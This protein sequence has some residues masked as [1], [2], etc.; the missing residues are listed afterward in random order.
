MHIPQILST[1]ALFSMRLSRSSV[2]L[3]LDSLMCRHTG[4][5]AMGSTLTEAETT[6]L[7]R[8]FNPGKNHGAIE[9][10]EFVEKLR[11]SVIEPTDM[12][13]HFNLPVGSQAVSGNKF[14][15]NKE[16]RKFEF[17]LLRCVFWG[18]ISK[19]FCLKHSN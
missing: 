17:F 6:Q 1:N 13:C 7:F 4:P 16:V 15:S 18:G 14:R 2:P 9:I 8:Y 19:Y 10:R 5:Q 11:L 3:N 12:V